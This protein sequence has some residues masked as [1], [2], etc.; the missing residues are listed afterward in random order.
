MSVC[1]VCYL[2]YRQEEE[3]AGIKDQLAIV[4]AKLSSGENAVTESF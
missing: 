4:Q 1:V 2:Y 3:L